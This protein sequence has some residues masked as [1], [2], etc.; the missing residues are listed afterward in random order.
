MEEGLR[1][2]LKEKRPLRPTK[3][4]FMGKKEDVDLLVSFVALIS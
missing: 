1:N 2:V 3:E 4:A